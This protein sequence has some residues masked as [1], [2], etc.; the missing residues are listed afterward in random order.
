M[1]EQFLHGVEVIENL[2][3]P[4]PIQTVKSSVIGLVGTSPDA[5]GAQAANV[6]IRQADCEFRV[7]AKK[8]GAAGN[9]ISI[10][11]RFDEK[12]SVTIKG[13][14]IT[15]F[16]KLEKGNLDASTLKKA[17]DNHTQASKLIAVDVIKDGPLLPDI[18]PKY[19]SLGKDDP[20]PLNTP[21]LVS[22]PSC[23]ANLGLKGTLYSS[24]TGIFDQTGAMVVVVRVEEG[25][26][27][28]TT[29]SNIIGG[30]D[31]DTGKYTGLYA[32]K[33]AESITGAKP[34][35]LIA[36]DYS[37]EMAVASKFI[38]VAESLHAVAVI[39]G[40]N[41]TDADAIRFRSEF[42][43]DRLFIIEPSVEIFEEGTTRRVPASPYVAG[44]IAKIDNERG[45]WHS[46][47][48]NEING[49]TGLSRT[50]D[51][52]LGNTNCSANFLNENDVAT[53]IRKDGFRLWGNRTTSSDKRFAFLCVRRTADMI[54]DSLQRAIMW[55]NDK[56]ISENFIDSIVES[57]N[58]YLRHLRSIGAIVN[59]EAFA[60]P[61]LNSP[62]EIEQGKIT[63]D[64]DFTPM[65]P[66][67]HITF[68]S[69]ITNKYLKELV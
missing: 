57:V 46:P 36:P 29:A 44:L 5:K 59:G 8:A 26:N 38:G 47:S 23:L 48:N 15:V 30:I 58:A 17:I 7:T 3:G 42:G 1:A 39:D 65:Y 68:R 52:S 43:S 40:P 54:N 20:F 27:E 9:N 37:G 10:C 12:E 4:R 61:E 28:K 41:L 45:F 32:L 19:L 33:S 51:F 6:T 25:L 13:S 14:D 22:S 55:A 50:I 31:A 21:V 2:D 67:E 66:A 34:R 18:K 62:S 60:N 16:L 35:I 69:T 56:P 53:I 64:F 24:L 11:F 49:I 63:I